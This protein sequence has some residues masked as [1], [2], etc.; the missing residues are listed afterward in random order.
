MPSSRVG[1]HG[2]G[3][4]KALSPL[5]RK[6]SSDGSPLHIC[7]GGPHQ[8]FCIFM[9]DR[10]YRK[11]QTAAGR[12]SI[13][14][15]KCLLKCSALGGGVGVVAGFPLEVCNHTRQCGCL[16][17]VLQPPKYV[18][19][20]HHFGWSQ[21]YSSSYS[22]SQGCLL[23]LLLLGCSKSQRTWGL[24]G[25]VLLGMAITPMHCSHYTP[26]SHNLNLCQSHTHHCP[27]Q[28]K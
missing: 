25:S 28:N 22:G 14:L 7:P 9:H 3:E 21:K 13:R 12:T 2:W 8:L 19:R 18:P 4:A 24:P 15:K 5:E 16:G 26:R 11:F 10:L 20:S 27:P 6:V 23:P 1:L 17:R